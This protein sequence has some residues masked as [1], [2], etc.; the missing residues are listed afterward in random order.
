MKNCHFKTC[1]L[2]CPFA[3]SS[4]SWW[5]AVI[6]LLCRQNRQNQYRCGHETH[7]K[8]YFCNLISNYKDLFKGYIKQMNVLHLC[9]GKNIFILWKMKSSIQ[10]GLH[11]IE[12]NFP[13]FNSWKFSYHCTH[14]HSLFVYQLYLQLVLKWLCT[15]TESYPFLLITWIKLNWNFW[16]LLFG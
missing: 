2:S 8:L 1:D 9:N 16:M 12:W 7:F 13:S 14:K 10:L 6:L 5:N 4:W 11:L 3:S 15:I